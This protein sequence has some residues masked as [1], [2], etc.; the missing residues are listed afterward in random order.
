MIPPAQHVTIN[1]MPVAITTTRANGASGPIDVSVA[2]WIVS[3][4]LFAMPVTTS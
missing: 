3:V 4:E 2:V 1:G